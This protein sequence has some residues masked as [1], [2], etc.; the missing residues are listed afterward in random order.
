MNKK[1]WFIT[2]ISSGLGKAIA[3]HAMRTGDFVIGTFREQNH[4]YNFNKQYAGKGWAVLLDITNENEIE[5]VIEYIIEKFARID[6]LVNNAGLGF[7]GAVEE[8]SIKEIREVFETNFFAV[9]NIT[10]LVLPF[11]RKEKSGHIIQISSHGGIKAIAGVGIYNASKFALDGFSEA[12]SAEVNPLGIKVTI[13][14]P[15]PFRTNFAVESLRQAKE[16]IKEY[17]GSAGVFRAKL[18]SVDGKQEGDPEKAAEAIV[19]LV[20]SESSSLR[21]PLGPTAINSIETKL[22]SVKSD[23]ERNRT[24]TESVVFE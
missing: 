7:A 12:L 9:F 4:V 5:N 20:S 17:S 24:V 13:I 22:K 2:G 11:M 23:L 15:G 3:Q 10:K 19:N 18:K 16:V 21:F 14:E 8:T 6:V 1:V